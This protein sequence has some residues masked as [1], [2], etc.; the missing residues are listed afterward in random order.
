MLTDAPHLNP[1]RVLAAA[2]QRLE[3]TLQLRFQ[4]YLGFSVK[5]VA[6][7]LRFRRV[8]AE[9]AW[10]PCDTAKPDW[11][12][13]LEQHGYHDQSHLSHDFT[14]FLHQSPN[15]IAGQLLGGEAICFTHP[16]LLARGFK[17]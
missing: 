14:H 12:T 1:V 11:A 6:R 8:L 5:E 13:V 15:R 16:E 10:L 7:F 17:T 2:G 4:K 3:R 9:V